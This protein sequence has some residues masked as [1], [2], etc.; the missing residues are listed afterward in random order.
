MSELK[1]AT[2]T[3]PRRPLG[4]SL[5]IVVL[6]LSSVMG[7]WVALAERTKFEEA[8][9]GATGLVYSLYLV[10]GVAVLVSLWGLW[11][12]RIWALP[13]ILMLS[14]IAAILDW[15][16]RAPLAHAIANVAS[17]LLILISSKSILPY[18]FRGI[19][20]DS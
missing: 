10:C 15:V 5:T 17:V 1:P 12:L 7:I 8:F 20:R 18:L 6:A 16:A 14:A 2:E 13:V 9:P 11:N 4:L 3:V 19:R